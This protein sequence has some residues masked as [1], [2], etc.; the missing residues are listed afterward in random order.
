MDNQTGK[1]VSRGIRFQ[2]SKLEAL[3]AK[4]DAENV[5]LSSLV[6][7]GIDQVLAGANCNAAI[8]ER[9]E[10][11]EKRMLLLIDL[12]TKSDTW[13]GKWKAKQ[14]A[15]ISF[16]TDKIFKTTVQANL[17]FQHL[18]A[19]QAGTPEQVEKFRTIHAKLMEE[20]KNI[21]LP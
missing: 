8:V 21:Q 5:T 19:F 7:A 16:M 6:E 18:L 20:S 13:D 9:V 14:E 17:I 4:A 10:S 11:L 15:R 12:L 2:A 1:T 3:Q